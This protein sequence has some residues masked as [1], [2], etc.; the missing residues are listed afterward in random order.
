LKTPISSAAGAGSQSFICGA[1]LRPQR[2]VGTLERRTCRDGH[3]HLSREAS[4]QSVPCFQRHTPPP[5]AFRGV[6][7]PRRVGV[8][9]SSM[10]YLKSIQLF[11][12][13][14]CNLNYRCQFQQSVSM[15]CGIAFN[16]LTSRMDR[17]GNAG[18]VFLGVALVLCIPC[19][20]PASTIYLD[21]NFSNG[22]LQPRTCLVQQL[23]MTRTLR[24]V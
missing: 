3:S 13:P 16:A 17:S 15:L 22:V 10:R 11:R 12:P 14:L 21:D 6:T 1:R 4:Q 24:R 18:T 20:S 8:C 19:F 9:V 2:R 5:H 23:D 7:P